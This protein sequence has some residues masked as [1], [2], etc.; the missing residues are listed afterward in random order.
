MYAKTNP[1]ARHLSP[2]QKRAFAIVGV[3]I[4]LVVAGFATWSALAPDRY[5]SSGHGCVNLTLPSSTG[6]ATL[7][8]CG[9]Q[10]RSFCQ[11]SF[12]SQDQISLRARPQ[13]VLAGLAP[14]A[15]ASASG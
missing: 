1:S 14:S 7:H 6:G 9:A 12:R 2:R 8:Y 5:S 11:A 13:C 15:S 3:L 10:A 4:V